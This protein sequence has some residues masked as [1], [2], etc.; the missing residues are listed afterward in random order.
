M[1]ATKIV[2]LQA[3]NVKRLRAVEIAPDG[4]LVVVSGKNGAGKSS[5]LDAIWM[6]LG[7]KRAFPRRPVREGADEASIRLELDG[8]IVVTRTIKPDGSTTLH[9]TSAD[10]A[11]YPS[12]QSMLDA[13]VAGLSFDPLAF[14][15]MKPAEQRELLRKLVGLDTSEIDRRRASRYEARTVVGREVR[16]LQ[17]EITGYPRHEAPA[18]EVDVAALAA[19]LREIDEQHLRSCRAADRAAEL[20][21]S[22]TMAREHLEDL[23][24]EE[25]EL[26]QRLTHLRSRI[27]EGET[28]VI[29]RREAELEAARDEERK[30]VE[31]RRDREP[32]ER[33]LRNAES[34]NALVRQ[35]RRRA[36]LDR[37]L[38]ETQA[39]YEQLTQ[40]IDA[41]DAQRAEAIAGA[42]YPLPGLAL[43]E[44]GVLLNGIPLEQASSAEQL[45][46]S[47]A[48]GLALN[49][50]L[51]VLLVRD[52]SLLDA[53]SLRMVAELAAQADAQVWLEM[54]ATG[55]DVG[56]VIEDGAVRAAREAAE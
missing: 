12:P 13:L 3:E 32:V 54:V 27:A 15:R 40:E 2:R 34:I 1:K 4:A 7:G 20:A 56:V 31:A 9:V 47:V 17:G 28:H 41:L 18:E 35:N 10:G 11:R 50:R 49:P 45:R 48:I 19:E 55:E 52:G 16:R 38:V 30:L 26:E 22:L 14:S 33:R 37:K 5:V 8:G 6:A 43:D 23:R 46:A 29:P 36:E 25:R 42:S 44:H 51:R 24:R 21:K 39:T 53:D